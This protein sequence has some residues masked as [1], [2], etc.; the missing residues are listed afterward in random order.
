M[1]D[2]PYDCGRTKYEPCGW[3]QPR[4]CMIVHNGVY[5]CPLCHQPMKR[6]DAPREREWLCTNDEH[7]ADMRTPGCHE[8]AYKPM[9]AACRVCGELHE[10]GK[11]RQWFD[12]YLGSPEGLD[13]LES[14]YFLLSDGNSHT[15]CTLIDEVRRLRGW[16]MR[17]PKERA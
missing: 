1:T 14:S 11:M 12:C 2:H 5:D 16:E 17:F 15:I 3:A 10:C 6:L 7:G 13:A 9:F 8:D 4:E